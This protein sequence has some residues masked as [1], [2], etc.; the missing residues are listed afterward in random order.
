MAS[1]D[2]LLGS[3]PES[4]RFP[5]FI[6]EVTDSGGV[7]VFRLHGPVGKDIGDQFSAAQAAASPTSFLKSLLIDFAGT[8]S[9]DFATVAFLVKLIRNRMDSGAR[10]GIINAPPELLAEIRIAKVDSMLLIF[11]S[12]AEA[13]AVLNDETVGN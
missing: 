4:E 5:D 13:L 6:R 8:T 9:C 1:L 7:R 2:V 11:D 10:V 12:E 3:R